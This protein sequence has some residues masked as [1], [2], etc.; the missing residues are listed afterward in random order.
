[1][2]KKEAKKFSID[3]DWVAPLPSL[4]GIKKEL[5]AIRKKAKKK[6]KIAKTVEEFFRSLP[7]AEL[8][9]HSTA[10]ADIFSTAGLAWKISNKT[11]KGLQKLSQYE[12]DLSLLIQDFLSPKPGNLQDYLERYDLLK[13]Y[14]ILD[15]EAVKKTSYQ[16]AIQ[17]FR[18]G[19]RILEIRTSIKAGA[20]GDP[21]SKEVMSKTSYSAFDELCAR[22]DGFRKA[23]KESK[24]LLN[25]FLIIS[26][27]RQDAQKNSEALL[28]EVIK[29]RK[30]LQDKY[31]RDYIIGVDIA[32]SEF[33]H[34]A[35]KFRNVFRQ[36]CAEGLKVTAHAGEEQ[37][38][39][40]GSIWQA[41][42]SGAQRIGHGTSLY[43]PW[44]MLEKS[45]RH[46]VDGKKK[47]AF[48]LSLM[49]G[50]AFEMCLTS[51]V[52]CGAEVTLNYKANPNGRPVPVTRPMIEPAD[53]PAK[54]LFSLGSLVYSGRSLILP[55]PCTD[56]IYTLNTDLARE[57]AL[58]CETFGLGLKEIMA[59][60]RFSIRHSFAPKEVKAKALQEWR[61][62]AEFYLD[63]PDF[64]TP[65]AEAKRALH[66]YRQGLRRELGISSK[67]VEQVAQEV[68]R[69]N[70]YLTDYL[71]QRF[72]E[73]NDSLEV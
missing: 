54:I 38:A 66:S 60:A 10:M 73:Q 33:Q 29:Y 63:D 46:Q 45:I 21:R 40:E 65:D 44:P 16:G 55:I 1:M 7:K 3:P 24:G 15:L 14:I 36:A 69:S 23:E 22:V 67:I 6:N 59:V 48:I 58:T 11:D 25:V 26:F 32:G 37:G 51:N 35:K 62:F 70:Q 57:Y 43:L 4:P 41:I 39:G 64:S 53:Y 47:N 49:F 42:N 27:R 12:G 72:H 20:F 68:Y 56:G 71:Y 18:N 52:I 2:F 17:A 50:T 13:N 61:K 28:K 5:D 34:K 9:L 30:M 19:V 31:G 8:H